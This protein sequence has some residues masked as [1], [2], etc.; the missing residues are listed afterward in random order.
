MKSISELLRELDTLPPGNIYK[1]SINGSTYYYHQYFEFGKRIT[2]IVPNDKK[3]LKL[4]MDRLFPSYPLHKK[5]HLLEN[6]ARFL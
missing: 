4:V 6:K 3:C 1:K 2:K 5:C